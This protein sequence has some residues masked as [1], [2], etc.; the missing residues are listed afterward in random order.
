MKASLEKGAILD[1]DL[2]KM[3]GVDLPSNVQPALQA[4]ASRNMLRRSQRQS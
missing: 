2:N 3:L 4:L 1:K